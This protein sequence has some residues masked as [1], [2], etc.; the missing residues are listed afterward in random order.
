MGKC[1]GKEHGRKNH[2]QQY[3]TRA[4]R[5]ASGTASYTV[6]NVLSHSDLNDLNIDDH[7]QYLLATDAGGRVN[8]LT[9]WTDLTDG[10]DTT[11]HIH[12]SR[13]YTETEL[14]TASSANIHWTNVSEV[15]SN[16]NE[17]AT[18]SHTVLS[19][20]GSNT[21]SQIDT[22]IAE[23]DIHVAHS[24]VSIVAGN[25]LTGG[26]TIAATRTID[27]AV[28][29]TLQSATAAGLSVE[30]NAVRFRTTS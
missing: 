1:N 20:I 26:G 16:L 30:A 19:D 29:N 2:D 18:R 9:K 12:D 24:T 25:G 10:G 11:V 21:H 23:S 8:F 5:N 4:V 22:H 6:V 3:T 13:Y 27:V 15:G 14:Q 17:I 7:V 28:A